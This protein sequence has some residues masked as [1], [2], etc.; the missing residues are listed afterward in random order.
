MHLRLAKVLSTSFTKPEQ[1]HQL[2]NKQSVEEDTKRHFNLDA[3]FPQRASA[4]VNESANPD[5]LAGILPS[6]S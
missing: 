3:T 2:E 1:Y 5:G 4:D 6:L